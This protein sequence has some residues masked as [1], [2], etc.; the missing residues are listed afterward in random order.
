[1]AIKYLTSLDLRTNELQFA[2]IH[3]LTTEPTALAAQLGQV[4]F[5]TVDDKLKIYTSNGWQTVGGVTSITEGAGI[6]VSSD[7]LTGVF[8]VSHEDT[9]SIS[10]IM[11][12]TRTYVSGLMFDTFGHVTGFSTGTD[13]GTTYSFSAGTY[14]SLGNQIAI[15]LVDQETAGTQTVVIEGVANETT[16]S[17]NSNIVTIGLPNDVTISGALVVSG[18][19]TVNGTTT[20]VN[21][22]TINLADNII[23][24]NSNATGTPTENAGIEIERGDSDNRSLIWN[25]ADGEWQLQANDGVYYPIAYVAGPDSYSTTISNSTTVTHSLNT[26]DVIVQ[27]YDTVTYETVYADVARAG[28]NTTT[29]TFASTPTNPIRVLVQK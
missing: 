5:N 21:T 15:N 12:A 13:I 10:D 19:L 26:F 23:L 14:G 7:P 9:S 2:S 22:E 6:D 27:L 28:V 11:P 17:V 18:D 20:T 29:I 1:M 25:E 16:V 24:F 4:Y 3:P 8:T